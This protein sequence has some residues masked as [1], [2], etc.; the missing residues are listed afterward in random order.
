MIF[1]ARV[2]HNSVVL[3]DILMLYVGPRFAKIAD[4]AASKRRF[5]KEVP[6]CWEVFGSDIDGSCHPENIVADYARLPYPNNF[7]D[8]VVFDPPYGNASTKPRVDAIG[9]TYGCHRHLN[10]YKLSPY[11]LGLLEAG[12]IVKKSGIVVVKCQ[13]GVNGGKQ[14]WNHI[15]VFDTA[16]FGGLK[17]EDLFV[18][19]QKGKPRMRHD[20]QLHARKNHSYFWVFR[21]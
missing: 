12:R 13:D 1:T 8:A 11:H 3:R 17:A 2:A 10:A 5:W 20:H 7:F 21:K 4:I 14:H 9:N 16:R 15:D 18:V 6:P 19:V